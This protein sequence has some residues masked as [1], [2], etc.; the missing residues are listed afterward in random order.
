MSD[1]EETQLPPV[2]TVSKFTAARG[3]E[4]QIMKNV[5]S[6]A[7]GTKLAFQKLP[8][9]MR[10]RAMS[11]NAKRLPRR[12]REIHL[13]Q[14]KKSGLLTQQKRASRKYRRRPN[15][16][17]SSYL[18]RQK[19][20]KWLHTHLWHAKRFHMIEKWGYK[21]PY[22][23]CDKAFKACYRATTNHCLLQD[24]SYYSC[25]EIIGDYDTIADNF[26][27]IST[28][29]W[30]LTIAAKAY[31]KGSREGHITIFRIDNK[32]AI[33]TIYFNW[34]PSLVNKKHVLWVW[35]HAAYYSETLD[36]LISC[37]NL[38]VSSMEGDCSS[39]G[40]SYTNFKNIELKELNLNRFRLTGPLVNSVL[41]NCFHLVEDNKY[42][43]DWKKHYSGDI[44]NETKFQKEYWTRIKNITSTTELPPHMILSLVIEDPRLYFPKKRTKS[45][46]EITPLRNIYP[47]PENVA[48]GP[49]WNYFVRKMVAD[50][51]PSNSTLTELRKNLL[52]PGSDLQEKGVPVPIMLIQRPGK[53]NQQN[54]G[55]FF[56]KR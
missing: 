47:L 30:G 32:K 53:K 44:S 37:F 39:E 48:E 8:R 56:I 28:P 55:K 9:H 13:N 27:K 46:P 36:T 4:I 16:L 20:Y 15:N 26:K 19:K 50:I 22:R 40:N 42:I 54:I 38:K 49:I 7:S 33:G 3:K 17:I 31:L 1:D 21:L 25:I 35:I 14:M 45:V 5:L 10:R 29:S 52:V 23:P 24:I 6:N 11:H 34:K 12:L 41:Q 51:K 43:V 18:K 2:L